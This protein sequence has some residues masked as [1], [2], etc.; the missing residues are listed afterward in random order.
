MYVIM[1]FINNASPVRQKYIVINPVL[2]CTWLR[3]RRATLSNRY[4]GAYVVMM[5]YD[6]VIVIDITTY[7]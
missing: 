1:N 5:R 2:Y 4:T 3:C 6:V 7:S